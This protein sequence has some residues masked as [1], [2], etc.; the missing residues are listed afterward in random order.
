AHAYAR[1]VVFVDNSGA[2]VCLGVLPFAR[3]LARRGTHVVLA[4]NSLPAL[5]DVTAPELQDIVGRA[6]AADAALAECVAAG[7]LVVAGTGSGGPCLDLRKLDERLVAL[8]AGVDLVVIVGMGRAIHSNYR[9][10]FT[11]DSLK[12]A[13]FKNQ[14]AADAAGA[15]IYDCLCLFERGSG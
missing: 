8:C 7:R 11:C 4:A 3:F 10:R 5:N 2:D 13:V 9:A 1:A 12:L 14:M 6:V 15:N